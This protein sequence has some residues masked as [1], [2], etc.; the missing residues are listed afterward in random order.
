M[1]VVYSSVITQ[2]NDQVEFNA[3]ATK[4]IYGRLLNLTSEKDL[5]DSSDIQASINV[6]DE[7]SKVGLP[8]K[9]TEDDAMNIY[10]VC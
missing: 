1:F 4:S 9:L 5:P 7:M 8:S 10:E 2:V 3:N 6:M